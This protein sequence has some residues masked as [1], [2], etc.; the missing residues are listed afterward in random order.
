MEPLTLVA[1]LLVMYLY[2]SATLHWAILAAEPTAVRKS[3]AEKK[4]ERR[5]KAEEAAWEKW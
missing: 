4:Y 1:L 5:R 3:R 2:C